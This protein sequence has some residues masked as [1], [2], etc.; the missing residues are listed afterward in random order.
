MNYVLCLTATIL[1]KHNYL[2]NFPAWKATSKCS[3][4]RHYF[5]VQGS[6]FLT[7]FHDLSSHLFTGY[8]FLKISVWDQFT[9]VLLRS[10]L[11]TPLPFL[12]KTTNSKE[13]FAHKSNRVCNQVQPH[14]QS[15]SLLEPCISTINISITLKI[16]TPWCF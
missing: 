16:K 10:F 3:T 1:L 11:W 5:I 12:T 15:R 4:S 7:S 2:L 9:D 14:T 6:R 13:Q 8:R